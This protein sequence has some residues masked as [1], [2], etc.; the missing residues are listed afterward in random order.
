LLNNLS[1]PGKSIRVRESR[2]MKISVIICTYNRADCLKRTLNSIV[3]MSVPEDLLWEIIVVDNNSSDDTK[4]VVEE[5]RTSS[6][7]NVV[8]AFE[9][10]QGLSYARNRSIREAKGEIIAFIDDD[11]VVDGNW[12]VRVCE[13]FETHKPAVMGGKVLMQGELAVPKWFSKGVSDPLGGFDRGDGII[14]AD[15][16]YNGLVGIGANMSFRREVFDAVGLFRTDLG[17]KGN[18]LGM[19]EETEL[20]WRIKN[21]GEK[22]IYYPAAFVHHCVDSRKMSKGYIRRWFF[23]IGGWGYFSDTVLRKDRGRTFLGIPGG[24]YKGAIKNLLGL[25]WYTFRNSQADAFV[26]EVNIISFLGYCAQ[27][28]R[29][30]LPTEKYDV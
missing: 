5:F 20:Y 1:S 9:G 12:L 7:L 13:V 27:R 22:C 2:K 18:K 3:A 6:G 21:R 23:R 28:V 4:D 19:G 15:N 30:I 29:T 10:E 25:F 16:H 24:R 17:R 14:I 11:V 8:Y 26:R